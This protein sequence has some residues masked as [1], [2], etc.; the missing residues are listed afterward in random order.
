MLKFAG[1][2]DENCKMIF[3][4]ECESKRFSFDGLNENIYNLTCNG[5]CNPLLREHIKGCGDIEE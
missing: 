1:N 4:E 2:F 5:W 3:D